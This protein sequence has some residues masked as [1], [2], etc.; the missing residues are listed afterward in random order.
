[1]TPQ[2][3]KPTVKRDISLFLTESWQQGYHRYLSE[4]FGW[5]YPIIFWYDGQ[6]VNFYHKADDFEYFKKIITGRL[7][8]D[9]ELFGKLNLDFQHNV[10]VLRQTPQTLAAQDILRIFELSGKIMSFYIFVVSDVFVTARPA[11]WESRHLSEG[12]LYEYDALVERTM[13]EKLRDIGQDAKFAH[14]LTMQDIRDLLCSNQIEPSVPAR[15]N[16][17]ILDEIG[18]HTTNDFSGYCRQHNLRN[19]EDDT[20]SISSRELTGATAQPGLVRGRAVILHTQQDVANVK[21]GD[22]IVSVMTNVNYLPAARLAAGIVTDEGGITCH[23]A[24]MARELGKPCLIG[25]KLATQLIKTG[26]K[27]ELNAT[28]GI[29]N[30]L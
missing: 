29:V 5:R 10:Q 25:T 3:L 1:M 17:Y 24:I 15:L 30:I 7:L 4:A 6:R 16:G 2:I 18:L 12:I 28:D 26:D 19:P 23:A 27:L 20:A 22:I 13:A 21:E 14:V 8:E 11:A 9:N